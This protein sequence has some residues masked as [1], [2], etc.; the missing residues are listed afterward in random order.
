MG[1][2]L[3]GTSSWADRLLVAS[4]WYPSGANTPQGRLEYYAEHFPL[5]EV[6]TSFYAIPAPEVTS[7]WAQH[8]P[9]S[10]TFNVKA[11]SLFTGHSTK[12]GALP[13]ELRP[14][15]AASEQRLR[16]RD[17]PEE[18]YD[19]L[20]ARF[21]ESLAPLS[22]KLG[23]VLLQ[24]PPWL[25]CD[26][27]GYDRILETVQR[28]RPLRTAVELRHGSWLTADTAEET[29]TF[30]AKNDIS[31]CCVDMPQGH[32]TSVPPILL[33]TAEPAMLRFHGRSRHW[34]TG[35]KQE[36]FRYA[37]SEEE[38]TDWASQ[39]RELSA[40]ADRLH[41]LFNNCCAGQAQRDAATL[42]AML[43]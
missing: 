28:C 21:H 31:F 16:R 20:W 23:A 41:V 29:L 3:I 39:L 35:D 26:P 30:L 9:G 5:V 4:G 33:A 38:L 32:S 18:A 8:T 34:S 12:A 25:T 11:F 1:E 17:L 27:K 14:A 40:E 43:A 37:Y 13:P 42:K 22:A 36:K 24:F 6:D 7:A 10:F 19:K 15:G 2:I